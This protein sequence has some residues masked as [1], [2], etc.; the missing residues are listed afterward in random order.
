[1]SLYSIFERLPLLSVFIS[2]YLFFSAVYTIYIFNRVAFSRLFSKSFDSNISNI[3]KQE[4]YILLIL[5]VFIVI[6][7]IYITLI[8]DSLY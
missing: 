2:L 3:N 6:L 7:G 5:V 4:F 1:M 8:L